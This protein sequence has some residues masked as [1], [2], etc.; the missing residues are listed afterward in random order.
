MKNGARVPRRTPP[1]TSN[2][3]PIPTPTSAPAGATDSRVV[4]ATHTPPRENQ[5][6][7]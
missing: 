2:R 6:S 5:L 3:R 1:A 7:W 4:I